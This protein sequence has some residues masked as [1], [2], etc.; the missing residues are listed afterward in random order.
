MLNNFQK[1]FS[2]KK[3][4]DHEIYKAKSNRLRWDSNPRPF[5]SNPGALPPSQVLVKILIFNFAYNLSQFFS[6][7]FLKVI[8]HNKIIEYPRILKKY[9]RVKGPVQWGKKVVIFVDIRK[10]Y[11]KWSIFH[12]PSEFNKNWRLFF[13]IRL[14]L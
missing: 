10:V 4:S 1:N 9:S 7:F 14:V 3:L 2:E 12:K 11:E 5:D 6:K 8:Q 13:A